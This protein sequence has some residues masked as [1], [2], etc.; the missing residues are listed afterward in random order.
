MEWFPASVISTI[1]VCSFPLVLAEVFVRTREQS[2]RAQPVSEV[3][4]YRIRLRLVTVIVL[5][6]FAVWYFLDYHAVA[7]GRRP[8]VVA[9]ANTLSFFLLFFTFTSRIW[10]LSWRKHQALQ[11]E[12]NGSDAEPLQPPLIEY[13]SPASL[14]AAYVLVALSLAVVFVIFWL[15]RNDW[16]YRTKGM[17]MLLAG[18][19]FFYLYMAR[20]REA[21][22]NQ[23]AARREKQESADDRSSEARQAAARTFRSALVLFGALEL[24]A[25][26]TLT[27]N[28]SSPVQR[29]LGLVSQLS[30][31]IL[32]IVSLAKLFATE[33]ANRRS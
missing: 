8:F 9:I 4:K 30:V 15:S 26:M 10:S 18:A 22:A 20:L 3:Q 29:M 32:G 33:T 5:M 23:P 24:G 1:F 21:G 25:V 16:G 6:A 2:A 31:S 19:A 7:A 14:R 11:T 12:V 13:L 28:W 17:L 27:L